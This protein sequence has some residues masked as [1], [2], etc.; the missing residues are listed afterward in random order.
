VTKGL[1][2]FFSDV[3]RCLSVMIKFVLVLVIAIVKCFLLSITLAVFDVIIS[4]AQLVCA[5]VI[6]GITDAK[7]DFDRI[8]EENTKDRAK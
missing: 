1:L 6:L 8:R 5:L 7:R 3:W 2:G 4:Y